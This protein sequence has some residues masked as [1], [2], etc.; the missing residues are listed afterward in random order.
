MKTLL[1]MAASAIWLFSQAQTG[2]TPL[3]YRIDFVVN[4]KKDARVSSVAYSKNIVAYLPSLKGM[5]ATHKRNCDLVVKVVI[6]SPV[7][8]YVSL[9]ITS[10][11]PQET[12]RSHTDFNITYTQNI[13][14]ISLVDAH[15]GKVVNEQA[16]K[17]VAPVFT[18]Q[19]G[20]STYLPDYIGY[21]PPL[22]D[23]PFYI[24]NALLGNNPDYLK[25]FAFSTKPIDMFKS[26]KPAD[27][28][29]LAVDN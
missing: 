14:T 8:S 4:G 25:R 17:G 2:V 27:M 9:P 18:M 29:A 3:T 12:Q 13:F 7:V 23:D 10:R 28:E 24:Y 15:S 22:D 1:T 26:V 5:T 19:F 20:C 21:I 16:L 6:D 11:S